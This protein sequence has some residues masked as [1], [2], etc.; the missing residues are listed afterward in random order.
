MEAK[1]TFQIAKTIGNL[2]AN[3]D[4]LKKSVTA[5]VAKY[6]G[7]VYTED[8]ITE[9][10]S[11]LAFLRAER[12]KIDDARKDVKREFIKPYEQF[13]Q[14]VKETLSIYDNAITEIDAQVKAAEEKAKADKKIAIEKWWKQNGVKSVG[15][16]SLA[17]VWDERY[18]NK[19]FTEKKWQE[20]LTKK[21]TAIEADLKTISFLEAD[22]M[23][24]VLPMYMKTLNLTDATSEYEKF[25]E[26]QRRTEEARKKAE[27]A[28]KAREEQERQW[29][30]QREAE[31]KRQEEARNV[32]DAS[33]IS[34]QHAE[35]HKAEEQPKETE[36]PSETSETVYSMVFSIEGTTE[37]VKELCDLLRKLKKEGNF[38]FSVISKETR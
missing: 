7:L 38:T 34:A 36:S 17:Q 9:A 15:G 12:K 37:P 21:A 13:E 25:K 20:D 27:E 3:F 1:I 30:E 22:M 8:Q 10:K 19:G 6:K 29:R 18:L 23:N 5:S 16:I 32:A 35:T 11:D 33:V 2:T 31:R 24:F 4:E 28:R 14:Q 26:N